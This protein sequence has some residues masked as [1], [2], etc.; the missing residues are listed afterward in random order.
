M[1]RVSGS[2][3]FVAAAR[4]AFLVA[5]DKAN[6]TRRLFLPLKVNYGEDRTGLAY[7]FRAAQLDSAAGVIETS[8][9]VWHDE[10]VSLTA[11]EVM[12]S[13]TDAEESSALEE[14]TGFLLMLLQGAPESVKRIRHHADEAGHAWVTIKRAKKA[15]G[16][17]AIKQGMNGGWRWELSSKGI[18]NP[19]EAQAK[20]VIPFGPHDPLRGSRSVAD[21]EYEVE[22]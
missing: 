7:E 1:V 2:L 4:A 14:A 5:K 16:I 20:N 8:Y 15:L 9:V 21:A 11:D 13:P 6:E 19:E 18:K 10:P 17:Q 12:S 3:A 22:V